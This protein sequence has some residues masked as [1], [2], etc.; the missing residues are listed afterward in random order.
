MNTLRSLERGAALTLNLTQIIYVFHHNLHFTYK[1]WIMNNTLQHASI[2]RHTFIKR[3]KKII[4]SY[5][6]SPNFSATASPANHESS[7]KIDMLLNPNKALQLK[8]DKERTMQDIRDTKQILSK[9]F[10]LALIILNI[11]G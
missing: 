11:F 10:P 7:G 5:N 6:D 1:E 8:Q 4:H 2:C 3:R 9:I